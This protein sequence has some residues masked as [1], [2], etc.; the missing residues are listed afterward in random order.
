MK[1][2]GEADSPKKRKNEDPADREVSQVSPKKRKNED[3]ADKK[4]KKRK[5]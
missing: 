5:V 4:T 2:D 1:V 3:P